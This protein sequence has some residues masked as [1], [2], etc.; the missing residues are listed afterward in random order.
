MKIPPY[1]EGVS[2]RDLI[3]QNLI[4]KS[5]LDEQQKQIEDL[6]RHLLAY[7]NAHTPPSKQRHYP[8]REKKEGAKLGAPKGHKGVTRK[9]PEPTESK[10]LSLDCCPHCQN[11]LGKPYRIEKRI[12]NAR[13]LY[14]SDVV[15][16]YI[17][18]TCLL[19]VT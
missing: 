6:K 19:P 5:R 12:I 8:K 14:R 3:R 17:I 13:Y 9:T 10:S 15:D 11:Q 4:L 18:D 16:L 2:K 1:L 7:E